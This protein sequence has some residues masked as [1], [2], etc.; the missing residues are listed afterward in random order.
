[1]YVLN[2]QPIAPDTPFAHDGVNYPSNWIALSSPEEKEAIGLTEVDEEPKPDEFY[3]LVL[4]DP[5]NPGQWVVTP[6]TPEEMKPRLAQYSRMQR[7][8]RELAGIEHM[9][10]GKVRLIPTD[11]ATRSTFFDF[12]VVI[13]RPGPVPP[14]VYD[15]R[16]MDGGEVVTVPEAQVLAIEQKMEDR[17]SGCAQTQLDL[18]VQ[19]NA[20]TVTTKEE[21]DA[22]YAAVP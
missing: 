5:D 9:V 18:Q 3:N 8:Y 2:G 1:M 6:F 11:P 12:R 19:I 22:A 15:F 21:I 14:T 4:A 7:D 20:G 16:G 10:A 17:I 13:S